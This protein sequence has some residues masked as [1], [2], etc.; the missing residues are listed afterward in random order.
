MAGRAVVDDTRMIE[1]S[2]G[3]GAEGMADIAIVYRRHVIGR[4]TECRAA[5]T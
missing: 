1:D 5:M 4:L 2:T 3:K